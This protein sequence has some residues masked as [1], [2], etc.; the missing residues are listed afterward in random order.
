M[1]AYLGFRS[2]KRTVVPPTYVGV[3][4]AASGTVNCTPTLPAGIA[5]SDILVILI[6]FNASAVP[7]ASGYSA[8]G[9]SYPNPPL[10]NTQD[11]TNVYVLWKRATSSESNPTVSFPGGTAVD[12]VLARIIAIRGCPYFG[13]PY[14]TVTQGD[15]FFSIGPGAGGCT[16]GCQ[17]VTTAVQ[18]C[19]I[20]NL[21]TIQSTNAL[22]VT[23]GPTNAVLSSFSEVATFSTGSGN[24]GLARVAIGLKVSAGA[25]GRTDWRATNTSGTGVMAA[26]KTI[27]FKPDGT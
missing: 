15:G 5:T 12:H 13:N 24:T 19:L 3:G 22:A 8:L 2:A 16:I 11:D 1:P 7:T 25:T 20:V 27:A 10:K 26:Y 23:S 21:L 17:T 9:N 14:D 18:N 4:T 6:E